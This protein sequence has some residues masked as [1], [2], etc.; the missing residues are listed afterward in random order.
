[1][2]VDEVEQT[3]PPPAPDT[4][5]HALEDGAD[6]GE[7]EI[8]HKPLIILD[9]DGTLIDFVRDEELGFVGVAFHPAQVRLLNGVIE[10]LRKLADA[11]FRFALATNQPGPAK[12]Q[13]SAEAVSRTNQALLDHL[14]AHD[15]LVEYTCACLHHPEGGEGGDPTLVGA[16]ECRK[17]KPGMFEEILDA[18][19]ASRETTWVVGDQLSDIAAGKAASLHTA[20]LLDSRRPELWPAHSAEARDAADLVAPTLDA[21]AELIVA[22]VATQSMIP[23]P[24]DSATES[25]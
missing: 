16:C 18:L 19:A 1:M 25:A 8:V 20:L 5:P 10:G 4:D 6:T 21:L 2:G 3:T 24:M 22:R 13:Y 9:R 7:N 15:I 17:P 12:G 14:A 11:G 23:D